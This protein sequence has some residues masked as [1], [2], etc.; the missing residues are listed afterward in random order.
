MHMFHSI[1][2][3]AMELM[4][5]PTQKKFAR[6]NTGHPAA[7]EFQMNHK[8]VVTISISQILHGIY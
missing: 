8:P 6:L 3:N 7:F 2:E 5:F 4:D 1:P